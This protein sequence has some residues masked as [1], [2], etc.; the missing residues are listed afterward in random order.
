MT[1]QRNDRVENMA[2][3]P[4]ATKSNGISY[5]QNAY[6]SMLFNKLILQQRNTYI[7]NIT[8]RCRDMFFGISQ[9]L[10]RDL[11]TANFFS[12]KFFPC[13]N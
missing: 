9:L 13:S 7:F 1:K 5:W 4:G 10:D 12:K 3:Q 2:E 8:H 6:L 11:F